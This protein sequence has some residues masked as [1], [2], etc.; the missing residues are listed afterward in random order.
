MTAHVRYWWQD[1][2]DLGDLDI[3]EAE[4]AAQRAIDADLEAQ[5]DAA[6]QDVQRANDAYDAALRRVRTAPHGETAHRRADLRQA[7]A[8]VLGA[9]LRLA[10]LRR[11]EPR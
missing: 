5:I 2:E 6:S 4:D 9:E 1:A 3:A 8:R 7:N 10:E 11:P